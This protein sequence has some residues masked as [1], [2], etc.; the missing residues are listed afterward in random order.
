MDGEWMGDGWAFKCGGHG[1]ATCWKNLHCQS[2]RRCIANGCD[3][4]WV[5]VDGGYKTASVRV[6]VV[7]GTAQLTSQC[8]ALSAK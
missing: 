2:L 1:E 4:M 6:R 5:G 8:S 7:A 3:A